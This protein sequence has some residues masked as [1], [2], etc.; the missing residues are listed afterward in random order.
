MKYIWKCLD[1]EIVLT[2]ECLTKPNVKKTNKNIVESGVKQH[3]PD[4][5]PNTYSL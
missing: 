2:R 1:V 5:I 3:Y 4:L